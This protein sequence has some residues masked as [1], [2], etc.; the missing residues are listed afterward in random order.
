MAFVMIIRGTLPLAVVGGQLAQGSKLVTAS[1]A[2]EISEESI[3]SS[4]WA[5]RLTA[6]NTSTAR[7]VREQ[8]LSWVKVCAIA[9]HR[10]LGQMSHLRRLANGKKVFIPKTGFVLACA[11]AVETLLP[12]CVVVFVA[13][14]LLEHGKPETTSSKCRCDRVAPLSGSKRGA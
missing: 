10:R 5:G 7:I 4:P 11:C 9:E 8:F 12:A 6:S 14:S 1:R 2:D 3:H 13:S